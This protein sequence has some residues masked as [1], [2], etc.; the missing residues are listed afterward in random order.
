ME[1]KLVNETWLILKESL[2]KVIADHVPMRKPKRTEKPQWLD[3]EL[4]KTISAK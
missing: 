4:H 1:G 3:A 2:E